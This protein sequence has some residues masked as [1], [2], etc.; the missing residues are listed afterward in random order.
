M[1]AF[2]VLALTLVPCLFTTTVVAQNKKP[3]TTKAK[4]TKLKDRLKGVQ[5]KKKEVKAKLVQKK[6]EIYVTVAQVEQ[7]DSRITSAEAKLDDTKERLA[8]SKKEQSKLAAELDKSQKR[9]IEKRQQAARRIRGMYTS[10]NETVLSVL[11][12]A[13]DVSDFAARKSILERIAR[14]DHEV[15]DEVK[16]LRD[17]VARKKKRQDAV[18]NEVARLKARLQLQEGE[19]KYAMNRKRAALG[20]L[21]DERDDLQEELAAMEQESSRIEAQIRAYMATSGGKVAP[22]VGGFIQPVNGRFSSPYGYRVHP[23][24]RSRKLHTGQDIAAPSGTPI[25]AAGSGVVISAGWRNGYGNTVIIDH[26]GGKSTLYG[27]CS[28]LYVSSGQRVS[29]GQRIAAVGSTGYST[30]PHL[31]FEVRINGSPVN[32]RW[33]F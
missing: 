4:T 15:F 7:L 21:R 10:R 22:H 31:H 26:G 12:G 16:V 14:H 2:A 23:I 11:I 6:K 1:R 9:L 24:S 3:P 29:M 18:V 17:E 30:G 19:L 33:Y 32:P 20:Q 13:R 25:K 28:R 5:A 8:A 27:H